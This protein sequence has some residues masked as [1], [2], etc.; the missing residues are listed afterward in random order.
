MSDVGHVSNVGSYLCL[1]LP[2][3]TLQLGW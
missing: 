2:P 3:K 1:L